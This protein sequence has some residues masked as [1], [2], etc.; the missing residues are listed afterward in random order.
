MANFFL[1]FKPP[2]AHTGTPAVPGWLPG[3]PS[4][5]AIPAP[6]AGCPRPDTREP[7][8]PIAACRYTGPSACVSTWPPEWPGLCLPEGSAGF[9]GQLHRGRQPA[10]PNPAAWWPPGLDL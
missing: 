10:L 7:A 9:P 5:L 2:A 4:S 3:Y 8:S 6:D 1:A